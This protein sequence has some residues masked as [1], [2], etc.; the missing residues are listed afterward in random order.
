MDKMMVVNNAQKKEV[1]AVSPGD[2]VRMHVK[3][4]EGDKER[5]QPFEGVVM[6]LKGSGPGRT[7]KVR[8]ISYG[9][10]VERTFL[11]HSP[12]IEKIE[13]VRSGKVRRAKLY[14]LRNKSGKKSRLVEKLGLKVTA[15]ENAETEATAPAPAEKPA[16]KP[17]EAAAP[18]PAEKKAEKKSAK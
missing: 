8:K 16:E 11:L 17:V 9:I 6:S 15:V 3:I 13:I 5:V 7:V 1:P 14:F 12:R 18:A 4:I 2:T 10:G